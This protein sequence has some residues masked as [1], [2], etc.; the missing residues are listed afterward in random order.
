MYITQK[1]FKHIPHHQ[2]ASR[3]I[4]DD[5]HRSSTSTP[6]PPLLPSADGADAGHISHDEELVSV[7]PRLVDVDDVAIPVEVCLFW[8]A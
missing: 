2:G 8:V 3:D 7:Q 4:P 5:L 1:D 6:P